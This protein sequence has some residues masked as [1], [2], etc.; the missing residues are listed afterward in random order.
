MVLVFWLGLG[1]ARSH[2]SGQNALLLTAAIT[3][4][5]LLF[6]IATLGGGPILLLRAGP[7]QLHIHWNLSIKDTLNEGHLSNEYT[8]PTK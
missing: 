5:T 7:I 8:V 6:L 3:S 1:C 4:D 2:L